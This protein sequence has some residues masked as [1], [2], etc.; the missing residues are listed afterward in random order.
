MSYILILYQEI[1]KFEKIKFGTSRQYRHAFL[2]DNLFQRKKRASIDFLNLALR[3]D[4]IFLAYNVTRHKTIYSEK[5]VAT[6]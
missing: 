2:Y 5:R 6:L 1:A 4:M 3:A